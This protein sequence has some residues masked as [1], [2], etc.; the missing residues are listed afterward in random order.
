MSVRE[1]QKMPVSARII[2]L[3][4]RNY[5]SLAD[6][7]L[8][9]EPLTVFV[10]LNGA[11]KSNLMD[12]LRFVRDVMTGRLEK[13][14]DERGGMSALRRWSPKG[15]PYNV[16]IE[17]HL[18]GEDWRA[19]YSFELGSE[20][21]G[22][23][24]IRREVCQVTY[25][26]EIHFYETANGKWVQQPFIKPALL[27]LISQEA[28]IPQEELGGKIRE[29]FQKKIMEVPERELFLPRAALLLGDTA[30]AE[31]W[32]AL[33]DMGFY[34][35]FPNVLR[36]ATRPDNPYPLRDDAQNLS[37]T[38]RALRREHP[39]AF[40]RILR[41]LK[42]AV[43]GV[44]DV[45]VRQVG[46]RLVAQI[47]HRQRPEEGRERAAFD[48]AQE[49]DGTLRILAL[50]TALFQEPPRSLVG[51][52]EPELNIHPGALA[53]LRDAINL[54]SKRTQILITTHSPDLLEAFPPEVFRVVEMVDGV[55]VVGPMTAHQREAIRDRLF[56]AGELFRIEGLF[57]EEP[58]ATPVD[59][60]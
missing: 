17:L 22:E 42:V 45:G 21:R 58:H 33:R 27:D 44:E 54:A 40:E 30:Y 12:V 34:A 11:G 35:V 23:F 13:A 8:T 9:L 29:E 56:S 49:A 7:D 37:S 57:R 60:G 14:V 6:V 2:S 53:V 5:R 20:R 15:R 51:I 38:L 24:R 41:F 10:G 48:L 36:E 55:T 46:G 25:R 47:Y 1:N 26:Q 32:N 18:Q 50:L 16:S 52:E 59:V 43:P 31:V 3:R 19:Q 28:L 39:E 4:V